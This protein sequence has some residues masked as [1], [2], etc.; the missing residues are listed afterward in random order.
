[1]ARKVILMVLVGAF[2]VGAAGSQAR[3]G[4]HT[5]QGGSGCP[6]SDRAGAHARNASAAPAI[7]AYFVPPGASG[8]LLCR[9]A[10]V[11]PK[12]ARAGRL[13]RAHEVRSRA[14][15]RRITSRFNHLRPVSRH[16]Y[17]SCPSDSGAKIL[18]FFRYRHRSRVRVS[19]N[20]VGCMFA[21]RGVH[22]RFAALAPGPALV[23][24]LEALTR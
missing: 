4:T 16:A 10:G 20:T 18:A 11:N 8:L 21:S 17:F 23:R 19:V 6:P 12:P 22:V 5:G 2:A 15:I 24:R 13:I 1:M 7:P 9:Y 14:T 3:S